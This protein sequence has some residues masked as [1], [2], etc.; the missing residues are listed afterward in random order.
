MAPSTRDASRPAELPLSGVKVLDFSGLV[1]GPLATLILFEAGAEVTKV[2][3]PGKGDEMRSYT[4]KLGDDSA[5]F[6]LLNRGK[7]SLAVDLKDDD[8]LA[9][10]LEGIPDFD[11]LVEQFRPG[12]MDRLGLGYDRVSKLNPGIVYCSI[13]GYGQTGPKTKVAGHDLNY[14]A[15]SGLLDQIDA[16]GSPVLPHALLGDIGGGTYPAVMNI[17][18][19]LIE[20]SRTG[21]G[22]HLDVSMAEGVFPF[23]YWGLAQG[24][25]TG[26][27]PVPGGDLV[28]GGS[29][30]Y[31]LYRTADDR[32]VA[33]APL[34][35]AFWGSF[36]EIV[37]LDPDLRDDE[38]D[39]GKTRAAIEALIRREDSSV[40]DERF[41]DVDVCCS[42]VAT[43][44]EA[45]QDPNFVE[46]GL[47]D[48][49]VGP[50][51]IEPDPGAAAAARPVDAPVRPAAPISAPPG[52]GF[53]NLTPTQEAGTRCQ[54]IR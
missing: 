27:W 44:E 34:E 35:P 33:A 46:R 42:T 48:F 52:T 43:L 18:L 14:V 8:Q 30:R 4:P 49:K 29:P 24:H 21:T 13:T 51:E 54:M 22:R 19:A 12:V 50:P 31:N 28:T 41:A 38:K 25:S 10:L 37:G 39:P 2:E 6:A 53:S 32:Y 17:L 40:W 3:R 47:F 45:V 36:C 20:R 15:E 1:P 5:N 26:D 7:K 16:S 11:V 9:A 23:L